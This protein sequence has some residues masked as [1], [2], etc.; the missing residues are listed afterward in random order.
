MSGV[1]RPQIHRTK[2]LNAPDNGSFK[3]DHQKN[4]SQSLAAGIAPKPPGKRLPVAVTPEQI[5]ELREKGRPKQKTYPIPEEP[6]MPT[7]ESD[8]EEDEWIQGTYASSDE[9]TECEKDDESDEEDHSGRAKLQRMLESASGQLPVK[10]RTR[11]ERQI[12]SKA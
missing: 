7:I 5:L 9:S 4:M 3:M 11:S 1:G 6:D 8:S 12:S 2:N 10:R